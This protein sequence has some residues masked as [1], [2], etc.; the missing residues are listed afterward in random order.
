MVAQEFLSLVGQFKLTSYVGVEDFADKLNFLF[1]VV[2]LIISMMVVTVKSYFFKP[3]ACYIATTPSG[4]NFDNYLENYCW[5]HGTI[6]IL[7]G[8]NIPQTDADWAIVDQTKRITYYQWVPFIL[9]LQCIMF[10][11]PRVIWQL[12]CYNKVGTN[13]ESLAIDADAASHSPPSERKDKIERIVRT[14]EDMLFQHRDYR[15]GKM[16]DMRR[17]IYKMCN[18]CVFSKHM[19]TWLVLSYILMKF[20]YGINVIGQLFLMK[21]FLGFNSSMSSF[22]YTILS[23]IADGKE[24]HQTGIFPRVTYCYIGEIKHLG[25]SNKYVGQCALPI[26]MLN[27]KIYVFLWFWVF[28]VGIITAISIPM[29]FFRI[30][31]LSRRSSFIKKF[32]M[33]HQ[34]YNRSDKQLINSF[35]REFLR[36]DGVFLIR[37][38]CINAGDIVTADIVNRLWEIYKENYKNM[39][40]LNFSAYPK[41]MDMTTG[42]RRNQNISSSDE[43]IKKENLDNFV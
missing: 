2:I 35:I 23:N 12:I 20:M 27:E 22:G 6:S 4:S 10:Y 28:L 14:I 40:F 17:N 41:P 21:K 43:S 24:W 38:I 34:A 3:L 30:A 32:L 29:W 1:S 11:V 9:G 19:G 42:L 7:P 31:I 13:L 16:A 25:A 8:E 26:N 37:M 5:V 15:Q 39:D 33:M 36:H 18:F